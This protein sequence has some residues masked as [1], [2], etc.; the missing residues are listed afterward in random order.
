M[1][2]TSTRHANLIRPFS[3]KIDGENLI[4]Y[5]WNNFPDFRD[6]IPLRNEFPSE[7]ERLSE[8]DNFYPRVN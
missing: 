6:F 3:L 7:F 8:N 4:R 1:L 2:A 5:Q